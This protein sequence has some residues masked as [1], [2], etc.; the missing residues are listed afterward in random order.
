MGLANQ[1]TILRIFLIPVFIIFIGYNKPLYALLVFIIA[2]I[3]DALDGFVARKFNQITT[4]G[5]VLDP[6]ADK[7]LLL[8]AFIFI[9]NSNLDIKFPFWYVVI[10]I[11]RDVY[12]LFGSLIIYLLK[13]HLTVKPS[14][15]GKLT[16]FFQILSV[17]VVLLAN[18]TYIPFEVI[19]STIYIA[20]IFTLISALGYTYDG[21]RQLT[22][23]E[24]KKI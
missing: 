22:A 1:L 2:G 9:Y 15:F 16:T 18:I 14:I 8:S 10:V 7:A 19:Y 12:I 11:S 6:I 20:T 21:L 17:V 4:I 24:N 5:K 13:G 23:N 3:T